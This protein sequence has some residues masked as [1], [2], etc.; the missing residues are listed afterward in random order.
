MLLLTETT[1]SPLSLH[2]I[3]LCPQTSFG[4]CP[5]LS[6]KDRGQDI[7]ELSRSPLLV[8]QEGSKLIS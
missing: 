2:L 4:E 6:A 8:D 5:S 3:S 1:K 7:L